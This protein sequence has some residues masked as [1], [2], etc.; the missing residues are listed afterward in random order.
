MEGFLQE[1]VSCFVLTWS[2]VQEA[3][4]WNIHSSPTILEQQGTQNHFHFSQN[5][6]PQYSSC[7]KALRMKWAKK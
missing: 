3:S 7:Y 6:E 1:V 5:Q 2:P 4:V